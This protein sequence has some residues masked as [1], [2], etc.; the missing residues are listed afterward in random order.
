MANHKSA[1]KRACQ[2]KRRQARNTSRRKTV[3][4]FEKKVAAAIEGGKADEAQKALV[5]F[6]SQI[7]RA[8]QKGVVHAK[9]ASRRV[10]RLSRQIAQLG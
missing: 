2:T 1:E 7:D 10:S 8:A 3:T 5:N 6:M 9:R 4:T